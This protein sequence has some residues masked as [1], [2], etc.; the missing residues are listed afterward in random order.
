MPKGVDETH[1]KA[2]KMVTKAEFAEEGTFYMNR[3]PPLRTFVDEK[4]GI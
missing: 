3:F 4:A 2:F 1:Y